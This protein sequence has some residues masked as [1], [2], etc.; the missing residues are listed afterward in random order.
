VTIIIAR[1]NFQRTSILGY[2]EGG[3]E[4]GGREGGEGERKGKGGEAE[5]RRGGGGREGERREGGYVVSLWDPCNYC[6]HF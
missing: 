2:E 6:R 3:R 5:G 4:S 1:G